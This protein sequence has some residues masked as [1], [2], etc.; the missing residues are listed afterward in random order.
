M[1]AS[2]FTLGQAVRL[3]SRVRRRPPSLAG[4]YFDLDPGETVYI[5]SPI[6]EGDRKA[7]VSSLAAPAERI[8]CEDIFS[9]SIDQLEPH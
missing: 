4:H 8:P 2:T 1:T 5:A 9:V 3:K 6:G 7:R